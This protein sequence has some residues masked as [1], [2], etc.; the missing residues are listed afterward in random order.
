MRRSFSAS[1]C[2]AVSLFSGGTR[3]QTNS[4]DTSVLTSR[5]ITQSCEC[6][7]VG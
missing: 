4:I 3:E 1:L 5:R 6:L 2:H 7:V